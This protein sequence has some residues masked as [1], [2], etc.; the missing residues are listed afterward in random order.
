MT[1]SRCD[2]IIPLRKRALVVNESS[3]AALILDGTAEILP[4]MLSIQSF[5]SEVDITI[6]VNTRCN[7]YGSMGVMTTEFFKKEVVDEYSKRG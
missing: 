3:H 2:R 7:N 6:S 5:G 4:I 1:K